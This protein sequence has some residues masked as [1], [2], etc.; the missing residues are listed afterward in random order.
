M[1]S[2]DLDFRKHPDGGAIDLEVFKRKSW[3]GITAHFLRIAAPVTYGFKL[4]STSNCVALHDLYRV[5][6]ETTVSGL[7]RSFTKD[8]RGK[9]AFIPAG[10]DVEG[11]TKIEK[12]A[13]IVIVMIDRITSSRLPID[14]APLGPRIDFD[15]QTL[16]SLMLRFQAILDDPSLD[17]PGYAETLA[18]LLVFDLTRVTGGQRATQFNPCGLTTSQMRLITEYMDNHLNE[19]VTISELAALVDLTRFHFIRAFKQAAGVPPL[20]FMIRRRVERAKELLAERHTSIAEVANRS[21]FG[22]SIQMTRAFRRVIG[23][24]PSAIRRA[25]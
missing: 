17:V 2:W 9:L 21:G 7:P 14:L 20:Q 25:N 22:S 3:P 16:R 11:W 19:K 13:S 4:K 8:L 15:D 24:T 5:D 23:T 10:C 18:E 1:R 12:A 6:G